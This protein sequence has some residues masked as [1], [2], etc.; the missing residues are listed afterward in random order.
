M[1]LETTTISET[2]T[3]KFLHEALRI[4]PPVAQSSQTGNVGRSSVLSFSVVADSR[5][6]SSGAF[7]VCSSRG[8][9]RSGARD[10]EMGEMS[11]SSTCPSSLPMTDI[12]VRSFQPT[13]L[14]GYI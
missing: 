10:F 4:C 1:C 13:P 12:V 9:F 3:R 6:V 8:T 14:C 2:T 11:T 5:A 7:P